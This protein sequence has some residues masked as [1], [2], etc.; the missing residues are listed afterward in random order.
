[1]PPKAPGNILPK[2]SPTNGADSIFAPLRTPCFAKS[3]IIALASFILMPNAT[4]FD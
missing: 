1:M 4:A 3:S 2:A